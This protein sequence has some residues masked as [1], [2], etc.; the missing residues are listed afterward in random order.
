MT[1][2][3]RDVTVCCPCCNGQ[4]QT[5]YRPSLNLDIE[6]FDDEYIDAATSAVC[7]TC[8][9]KVYFDTLIVRDEVFYVGEE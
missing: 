6:D 3:P 4:Y 5:W 7:P 9:H 2:P 1:S 8:G